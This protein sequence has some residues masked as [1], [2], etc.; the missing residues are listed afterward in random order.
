MQLDRFVSSFLARL[1]T[2]AQ[3]LQMFD[4]PHR[5]WPASFQ[6]DNG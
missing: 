2:I 4:S 5:R 6:S 3:M 1:G